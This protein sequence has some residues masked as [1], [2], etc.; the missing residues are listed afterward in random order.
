MG[1]IGRSDLQRRSVLKVRQQ[2][3]PGHGGRLSRRM[4]LGQAM[5]IE[6]VGA[7]VYRCLSRPAVAAYAEP[8][9]PPALG[10]LR[11]QD[12]RRAGLKPAKTK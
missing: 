9:C 8:S 2:G 11:R 7:N 4:P 6:P 12:F 5:V 3:L 1:W 10:V